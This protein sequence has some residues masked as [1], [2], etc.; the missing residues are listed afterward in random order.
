[1]YIVDLKIYLCTTFKSTINE[2]TTDF[3]A[4]A[5]L[6]VQVLSLIAPVWGAKIVLKISKS[7]Q[8]IT[9]LIAKSAQM[10]GALLLAVLNCRF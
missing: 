8:K 7:A 3:I 9:S 1:M 2:N 4:Q 6:P 5:W 10:Q